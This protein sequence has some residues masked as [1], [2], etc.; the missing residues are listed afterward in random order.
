[1]QVRQ[2]LEIVTSSPSSHHSTLKV[3]SCEHWQL[4]WKSIMHS[5]QN[6]SIHNIAITPKTVSDLKVRL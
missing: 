3:K 2:E 1:M 4:K 5:L 6:H